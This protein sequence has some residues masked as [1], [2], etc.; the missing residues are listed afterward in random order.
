MICAVLAKRPTILPLPEGRRD[1]GEVVQ[2]AGAEPGVVGDVVVAGLHAC[3]PGTSPGSGRRFHHRVDVARRAGDGL[4]QHAALQVEDAGGKVARFAHRGAEGG[5]DHGLRLLLDHRD[6]AVPLDLALDLRECSGVLRRLQVDLVFVHLEQVERARGACGLARSRRCRPRSSRALLRS[7]VEI[8][9]AVHR[10]T[11]PRP[12][13]RA[14]LRLRHDAGPRYHRARAPSRRGHR[15]A[16]PPPRRSPC[17]APPGSGSAPGQGRRGPPPPAPPARRSSPPS[18]RSS[19]SRR[20]CPAPGGRRSG[21]IPGRTARGW[22]A[23][24]RPS[25]R[26]AAAGPRSHAPGR[27]SAYRRCGFPWSPPRRRPWRPRPQLPPPCRPAARSPPP[28]RNCAKRWYRLRT[29]S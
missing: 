12:D 21:C 27:H 11:P 19:G 14:R 5:A 16:S 22:P 26:A 20:R 1:D 28:R 3:R 8:A 9:E 7:Q 15:P 18:P 4:G 24:P 17:R 23:R 29:T 13:Q 6:Q 10:T 2:V 25:C